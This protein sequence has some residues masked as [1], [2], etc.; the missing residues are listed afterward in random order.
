M[1]MLLLF[2][3]IGIGGKYLKKIDSFECLRKSDFEGEYWPYLH[4]EVAYVHDKNGYYVTTVDKIVEVDETEVEPAF[5]N[6]CYK[7]RGEWK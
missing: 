7:R 6:Y 5:G 2:E 4:D 3:K 1:E